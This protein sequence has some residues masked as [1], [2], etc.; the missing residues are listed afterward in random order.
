VVEPP[1]VVITAVWPSTPD[2]VAV[3]KAT[4][5]HPITVA[6]T[7]FADG[8]DVI[9]AQARWR[10]C[11]AGT[12]S[13]LPMTDVGNDRFETVM[14]V[15][16]LGAH[17][18]WID[19]WV[20]VHA[21]WRHRMVAKMSA[22]QNVETELEEGARLLEADADRLF[23]QTEQV[24]H[25]IT[26]LR[27]GD[28]GPAFAL[29]LVNLPNRTNVT[30][31]GPWPL[32]AE[33]ERAAVGAWYEL[34][35]RS[36]GGFQYATKELHRV[37]DMGFDVVYLPPIHPI[38]V[39]ARK[40]RNNT[41]GAGPDDPGSPWAIGSA[42]GGHEAI[43]PALGTVTDFEMF[44]AE[45]TKCN[46][47]VAL[48]FALQCSP[49]HPWVTD[50]PEWFSH[51]P[52]GSIRFAENPPK[53]YQ[54]IFP[55]DFFPPKDADRQALWEA[56]RAVMEL[57]IER[58]VRIF[59]VDN[60]HTKPFPFWEWLIGQTRAKYPDV[61]LLA[62]AFTRPAAMFRLGE[63]GFSQSYTYFT[64]RTTKDE[65]TEF[66]DDLARGPHAAAFRPNLWPNTPDILSGPLRNGSPAAFKVRAVLAATLGP[67]WGIYSGYELCENQPASDANEEYANSEKYEI[68]A[69]DWGDPNSIAPWITQLNAIRGRHPALRDMASLRFHHTT[70]DALIAY[71]KRVDDD[72][73]LTVVNVASDST[74]DGSL[75]ID[76]DVLGFGS[77]EELI[78]HDELTGRDF[79]WRGPE[80]YVRLDPEWPAHVLWLRASG[81]EAR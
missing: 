18:L 7:V 61:V 79:A 70:S 81:G 33:R 53:Q 19:G 64:W 56:C 68:K 17:E 73:V 75:R 6:A 54:D 55:I 21:T 37:A 10:L 1:R 32:W 67:S 20:D 63:I 23:G 80:P 43:D 34:F 16:D 24:Q 9:A 65:L 72:V 4:V 48:D 77:D 27:G 52:D 22:G 50:H 41:L 78:A 60:P 59:R 69:R 12:W 49:D 3:A 51:R 35:P 26:C 58:G 39:T 38:G 40:G 29:D 76:L 57:W 25:A 46:L 13:G 14:S 45:A 62:E 71:S 11:N 31:S 8:H 2:R 15:T 5:G 44:M 30:T 47:E 74:Q 66:G 36:F 28:P 42:A